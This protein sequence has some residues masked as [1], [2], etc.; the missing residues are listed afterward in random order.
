MTLLESEWLRLDVQ[1]PRPGADRRTRGTTPGRAGIREAARAEW[2]GWQGG[3]A[4]LLL[5]S[6]TRSTTLT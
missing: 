2:D 4:R 3:A 6:A 5:L 1:R